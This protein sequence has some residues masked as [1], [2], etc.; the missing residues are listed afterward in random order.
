MMLDA[1]SQY[2]ARRS[3]E[4]KENTSLRLSVSFVCF[5]NHEDTKNTKKHEGIPFCLKLI[6]ILN[7][8]TLLVFLSALRVFVVQN[9]V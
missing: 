5:L 1:N 9:Q 4:E 3:K 6:L 7:R 8:Q 2:R